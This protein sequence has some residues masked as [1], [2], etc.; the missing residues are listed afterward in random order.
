MDWLMSWWIDW[1]IDGLIEGR[2]DW[3][4]DGLMDWFMDWWIDGF[5]DGFIDGLMDW[6]IDWWIDWLLDWLLDWW[7]E[8]LMDWWIEGMIAGLID[9]LIDWLMD[10]LMDWWIDWWIGL[11][12][13]LMD[14]LMDWTSTRHGGL[15]FRAGKS[16]KLLGGISQ[17]YISLMAGYAPQVNHTANPNQP[18]CKGWAFTCRVWFPEG[19]PAWDSPDAIHHRHLSHPPSVH[20]KLAGMCG[21][22]FAPL[23]S[24]T[25]RRS[26]RPSY[27]SLDWFKGK[28][29]GKPRDLQA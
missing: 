8:W 10:W 11:V 24:R 19:V 9:W 20:P 5:I 3:L 18:S 21:A 7:I 2:I 25:R 13:W 16:I 22:S 28:L 29:T 14:G 12:D 15:A 6:L 27:R 17:H 4:I 1:W 23:S 26:P